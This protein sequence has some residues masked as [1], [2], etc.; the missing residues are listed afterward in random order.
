MTCYASLCI[1]PCT[2]VLTFLA[3]NQQNITAR[4]AQ[5]PLLIFE[6]NKNLAFF[7][8]KKKPTTI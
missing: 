4:F 8:T 5:C 6:T 7:E 2:F 1:W 3:P